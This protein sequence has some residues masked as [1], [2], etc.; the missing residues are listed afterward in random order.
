MCGG[1]AS[2][3]QSRGWA[4]NATAQD[5][6]VIRRL[7]AHHDIGVRRLAIGSLGALAEAHQRTAID[8]A[9]S[10][11]L[12]DS[13]VLASELCR[14]FYGGWGLSFSDLTA[15]DLKVLLSKLEDVPERDNHPCSA[16]SC[17]DLL[18]LF[19]ELSEDLKEKIRAGYLRRATPCTPGWESADKV[20]KVCRNAFVDWRYIVE[21]G[22]FKDYIM[23]VTY[24]NHATSSVLQVGEMLPRGVSSHNAR[25]NP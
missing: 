10:V 16:K 3:Y 13:E 25:G 8:L 9:G 23:H 24:L 6:E 12:G 7:L 22:G 18:T 19:N 21:E 1:V 17:H 11:E 4:N 20:F 15:G 2:S 5:I 14:L